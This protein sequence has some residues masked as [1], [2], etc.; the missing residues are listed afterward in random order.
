MNLRERAKEA[1]IR[2]RDTWDTVRQFILD[3][4][5]GDDVPAAIADPWLEANVANLSAAFA[6]ASSEGQE[7]Y[8]DLLDEL[9]IDLEKNIQDTAALFDREA[10]TNEPE[11][12]SEQ[13]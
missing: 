2:E 4:P 10:A 9:G 5:N 8:R 7:A 1:A 11:E 3:H 6:Y 13:D 12:L